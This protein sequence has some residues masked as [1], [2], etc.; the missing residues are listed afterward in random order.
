MTCLNSTRR[1]LQI[2]LLENRQLLTIAMLDVRVAAS[3]DDAEQRPSGSVTL[4]SSD[5]E[6]TEDKSN[7]QIVGMRFNGLN[8]PPNAS[9]RN[10]YLQFQADETGSDSTSLT[11]RG[12]AIDNAPTFTSANGN[13]SSRATTSASVAWSPAAWNTKGEAGPVQRTPNIALVI[14]EI[15]NRPGWSDGN[16]LAIIVSGTGKRTAESYNG[17][18]SAAPLLHL[19]FETGNPSGNQT[20]TTSGIANVHVNTDAPDTMIDLF[21]AFD[22]AEDPDPDLTYTIENNDNASLFTSTTINGA[23]YNDARLRG[24]D[25]RY[26]KYHGPCH[27]HRQPSF[28]RRDIVYGHRRSR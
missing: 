20:P 8:I 6:L 18:P 1:R 3:S 12:Q 5:L 13:V 10:A 4:T 7:Q 15:V 9:I 25:R 2:E 17:A 11:I 14:Q 22:D 28:V 24:F 21:A 19:E 26:G 16:S 27:R 23:G